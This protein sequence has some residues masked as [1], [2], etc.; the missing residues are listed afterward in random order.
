MSSELALLGIHSDAS[1]SQHTKLLI[2]YLLYYAKKEIL[3]RWNSDTPTLSLLMGI[4]EK[5]VLPMYKLM[6]ND[7][8]VRQPWMAQ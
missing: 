5:S 1:R 7:D 6:Y 2:L 8:K 3:Y 4:L